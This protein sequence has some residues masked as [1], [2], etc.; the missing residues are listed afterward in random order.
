MGFAVVPHQTGPI[1]GQHHMETANGRVVEDLVIG[2]LQKGGV[3]GKYRPESFGGQAR[4][5]GHGVLL[6][7]AYVKKAVL[8]G[9]RKAGKAGTL[10][11]SRRNG[12]D[13]V[14]LV[15]HLRQLLPKNR[16][17]RIHSRPVRVAG[18]NIKSPNA[19]I[20]HGVLFRKFIALALGSFHMDKGGAVQFPG[21]PEGL[22]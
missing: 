4:R 9:R 2:P 12:A 1:D 5:K 20:G 22:L 8:M 14:V 16:G 13:F 7:D 15:S 6:R 11:H 18:F 19:V 3:N 10:L 21:P 17:E